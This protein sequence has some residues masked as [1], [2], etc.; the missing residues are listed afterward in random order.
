[1]HRV[2]PY[3]HLYWMLIKTRPLKI[4]SLYK[5]EVTICLTINDFLFRGKEP[6]NYLKT[7]ERM[8]FQLKGACLPPAW[9]TCSPNIE[10]QKNRMA[11]GRI[12]KNQRCAKGGRGGGKSCA[13]KF[14]RIAKFNWKKRIQVVP[15]SAKMYYAVLTDVAST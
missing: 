6:W 12:Q 1:M 13:K 2:I 11:W 4:K 3:V 7:L 14:N 9:S 10:K 5:I 8:G 15:A